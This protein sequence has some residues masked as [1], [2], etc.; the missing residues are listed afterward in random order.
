MF[1]KHDSLMTLPSTPYYTRKLFMEKAQD[2][3]SDSPGSSAYH[4]CGYKISE[5]QLPHI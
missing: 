1:F 2:L 4:P 5:P 3:K